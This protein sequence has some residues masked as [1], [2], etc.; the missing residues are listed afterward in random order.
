VPSVNRFAPAVKPGK[1]NAKT[2]AKQGADADPLDA[3]VRVPLYSAAAGL[4]VVYG[5]GA[6]ESFP[7][8]MA[9]ALCAVFAMSELLKPKLGELAAEALQAKDGLGA[10]LMLG[11]SAACI[12]LGAL[13]GVIAM[14][15]ANG[16]REAYD[17]AVALANDAEGRLGEAQTRL[18]AVPTCT[19]EMPASRCRAQ[20]EQNAATLAD[21]TLTRDEAKQDRDGVR[22]RLAALPDPAP[23]VP[24]IELWQ[25]ALVIAAIEFVLFAVPFAAVR[26]RKKTVAETVKPSEPTQPEASP[27][28]VKV[29]DGGWATR[30][31]KYGQSGRKQRCYAAAGLAVVH[32]T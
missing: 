14:G 22:A 4:L 2:R 17:A 11:A 26:R 29:N 16:P 28:L 8:A 18:D 15:A 19:P 23:G 13:G 24:H 31:A 5:W 9:L 21:R 6:L 10:W 32:A 7:M 25:K 30:R 3:F 20:T 1:Q 27:K 12:A